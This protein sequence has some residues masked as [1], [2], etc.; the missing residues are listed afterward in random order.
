MLAY[1]L[2]RFRP[3]VPYRV[4]IVFISTAWVQKGTGIY[5]TDALMSLTL[6]LSLD[7]RFEQIIMLRTIQP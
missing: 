5:E 4:G 1:S 7:T 2:Y 6:S 3:P